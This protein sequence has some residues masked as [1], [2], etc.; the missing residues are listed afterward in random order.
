MLLGYGGV[1][2]SAQALTMVADFALG[3]RS[4][5][6]MLSPFEAF[7][8]AQKLEVIVPRHG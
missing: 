4:T 6:S 1:E 5:T 8:Q 3:R 2:L 7:R